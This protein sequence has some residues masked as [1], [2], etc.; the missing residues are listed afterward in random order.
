MEAGIKLGVEANITITSIK[1]NLA[2]KLNIYLKLI[3]KT[4]I[5]LR[6]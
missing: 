2:I 5:L 6:I 4:Y 3:E 1:F